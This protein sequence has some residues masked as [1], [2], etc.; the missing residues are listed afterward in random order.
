MDTDNL[1]HGRPSTYNNHKCHCD[2]CK[3]AWTKYIREGGY[4]RRY[5]KR[6]RD[7]KKRQEADD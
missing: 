3:A 1:I 7:E 6:L 2:E 5:Q 4:V